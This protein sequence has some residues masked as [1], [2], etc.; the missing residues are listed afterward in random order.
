MSFQS[1]MRTIKSRFQ[2]PPDISEA[3]ISLD[4]SRKAKPLKPM[5][6]RIWLPDGSG[7][8]ERDDQYRLYEVKLHPG[9]VLTRRATGGIA[10]SWICSMRPDRRLVASDV[11]FPQGLHFP[12][13][14]VRSISIDEPEPRPGSPPIP[15]PVAGDMHQMIPSADGTRLLWSIESD[16]GDWT[17]RLPRW[18]RGFLGRHD[19]ERKWEVWLTDSA[20]RGK[21]LLGSVVSPNRKER[22]H[23]FQ[24][25]PDGRRISFIRSGK[26]WI[27]TVPN[28]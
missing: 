2:Q 13:Y 19:K 6:Q 17:S 27:M 15:L 11:D 26:V 9:N 4:G 18:L 25:S 20:G 22:P 12:E 1:A 10:Y 7:W 14:R 8:M 21:S 23:D 28:P 24:W 3:L 16:C 5:L